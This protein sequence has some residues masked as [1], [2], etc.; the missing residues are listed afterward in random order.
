MASMLLWSLRTDPW[1]PHLKWLTKSSKAGLGAAWRSLVPRE[2]S[3]LLFPKPQHG[4]LSHGFS[5]FFILSLSFAKAKGTGGPFDGL[6][7]V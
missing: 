1:C 5:H 6:R 7:R 2:A 4:G 3:S